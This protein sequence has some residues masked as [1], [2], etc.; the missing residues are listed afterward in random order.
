M[1]VFHGLSALQAETDPG[2]RGG[3]Q[4]V[5]YPLTR[6]QARGIVRVQK[7]KTNVTT[8]KEPR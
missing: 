6:P 8:A 1:C 3:L 4:S 7:A 5:F 2:E